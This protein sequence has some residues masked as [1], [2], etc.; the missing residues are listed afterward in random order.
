MPPDPDD[1]PGAE[2]NVVPVPDITAGDGP[3][4]EDDAKSKE[5]SSSDSS[6]DSGSGSEDSSQDSS[7]S[8]S[9]SGESDAKNDATKHKVRQKKRPHRSSNTESRES[10]PEATGKTSDKSDDEA[11]R[12]SH[13]SGLGNGAATNPLTG[14]SGERVGT[15]LDSHYAPGTRGAGPLPLL[16]TLPSMETLQVLTNDLEKYSG[17]L[18]RSREEMSIAVYDKVLQGFKDTSCKCKDFIQDMGALAVVFFA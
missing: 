15:F 14:P 7:S 13:D 4:K 5:A 9:S 17:K 10:A 6:S 2:L 8:K 12:S 1:Q 18:F 11:K 16:M 3:D